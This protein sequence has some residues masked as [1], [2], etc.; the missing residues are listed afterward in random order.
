M[1]KS[2]CALALGLAVVVGCNGTDVDGNDSNAATGTS[3]STDDSG[4]GVDDP[5]DGTDVDDGTTDVDGDNDSGAETG[6][7]NPS[8]TC[9]TDVADQLDVLGVPGVSVGIIKDGQLMCTAVA[10]M[11]DIEAARPVTPDTVFAWASVSKTVTGT[12]A[13][14]LFD[15]GHFALDDDIDEHL[16][17]SARNPNCPAQPITFRQLLT[18]TSSIVDNDAI[19]DAGYT[20]GDSMIPLGEFVE[21]Y[22]VPGGAYYD[23]AE[24]FDEAC[25]GQVN[26][27]SNVAIGLLGHLVA[28]ISGMPFD[29]F[30]RERIFTPLGMDETSFHLAE[31]DEA[32]VAMPYDGE[33]PA[34]FVALGHQGFP[35]Y[36]DGLLRT[37]V[38]HMARFLAMSAELGEYEGERILAESTAQEMRRIQFPELDD[39]QGLVWFYDPDETRLGHDGDDPGTSSLLFFD[40]TDGTGALVVSN[41]VWPEDGTSPYVLLEAL[42]AEAKGG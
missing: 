27:Y 16:P 4:G 37:S 38:P 32:N 5:D 24:N 6:D 22:V 17:F 21:G 3:S 40:P 35:T 18:H 39:T 7:E 1:A 25:P 34:T 10:G 12:A 14:V 13:M 33:S 36:P 20:I 30:C 26:D 9:G 2:T 19:Y 15:D 42:F 8:P 29:R 11:A 28:E 41:G 31:L 23:A